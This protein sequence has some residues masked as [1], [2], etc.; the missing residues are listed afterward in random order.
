MEDFENQL[1]PRQVVVDIQPEPSELAKESV[2]VDRR[3]S[4]RRR[5]P[6]AVFKPP[7]A[8]RRGNTLVVSKKEKRELDSCRC[9]MK[10]VTKVNP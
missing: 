3:M 5:P 4:F 7:F 1:Q 9:S 6:V 10:S 8:A 2:A